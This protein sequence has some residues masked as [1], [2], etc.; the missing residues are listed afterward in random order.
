MLLWVTSSGVLL[1]S[2]SPVT[3]GPPYSVFWLPPT[4]CWLPTLIIVSWGGGGWSHW[5]MLCLC[6]SWGC[7]HTCPCSILWIRSGGASA[8]LI[9]ACIW[10]LSI[11]KTTPG[12]VIKR[13]TRECFT[14]CLKKQQ[15]RLVRFIWMLYW[16]WPFWCCHLSVKC[17][18]LRVI[19]SFLPQNSH[20]CRWGSL[21]FPNRAIRKWCL[22]YFVMKKVW[23]SCVSA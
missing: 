13:S 20:F 15:K 16:K 17:H 21:E 12:V 19:G 8:L 7:S 5:Q 22:P 11:S 18:F 4:H 14:H 6:C 10:H 2:T 23:K 9:I 1:P 3:P